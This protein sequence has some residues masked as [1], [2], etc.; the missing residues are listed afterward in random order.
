MGAAQSF[1]S[2]F[3]QHGG[4]RGPGVPSNMT[5]AGMGGLTGPSGPTGMNPA[6]AVGTAPLYAGQRLPPHTYPGPP[7]AQPLPRQGVK[8]IY[9]SEVRVGPSSQASRG[10]VVGRTP[11]RETGPRTLLTPRELA[12]LTPVLPLGI[13]LFLFQVC[14]G[15]QCLPAGQYSPG[16]PP[17]PSSYPGHRLPLSASGPPGLHYK[18]GPAPPGLLAHSQASSRLGRPGWGR[19]PVRP[20]ESEASLWRPH[21]P[22]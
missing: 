18:V 5:P 16:Q 4:P 13:H 20:S 11:V 6:R 17:A 10:A 8:R 19:G 15:Q 3:L 1:N 2:Q 7:Q 14:P 12:S 9:S 21:K 22:V